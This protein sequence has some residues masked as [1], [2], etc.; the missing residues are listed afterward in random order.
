MPVPLQSPIACMIGPLP[1]LP[2]LEAQKLSLKNTVCMIMLMRFPS[3]ACQQKQSHLADG[4]SFS[5]TVVV[6]ERFV[7]KRKV[8][9]FTQEVESFSHQI[10]A[11]EQAI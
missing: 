10:I 3:P 7:Q 2:S 4:T 1:R 6:V 5:L 8:R 11:L 9:E